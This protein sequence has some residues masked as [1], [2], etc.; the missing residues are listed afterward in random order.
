MVGIIQFMGQIGAFVPAEEGLLPKS[1][2]GGEQGLTIENNSKNR[3]S[4]Q[5]T[6]SNSQVS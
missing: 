1:I 5:D 6:E 4:R 3:H 2:A